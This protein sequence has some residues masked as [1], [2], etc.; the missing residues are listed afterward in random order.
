MLLMFSIDPAD[1][2]MDVILRTV[3]QHP[4]ISV[5]DLHA[6]LR[7]KKRSVTLQHLYRKVNQL[8]DEEILIKRK[9]T[10]TVNLMWLSYLE[11]FASEAKKSVAKNTALT[12]FPLREGQRVA[13]AADT[14][15]AVQT[16]WHHLLVQLHRTAPQPTLYKYYSHAWWVWNKR[17]LDVAFYKK[18]YDS[19]VRCLWLYGNNTDLDRSAV[20]M[21]PDILESRIS[22]DV[23]LPAEGYNLNV[24]G[25]YVFECIFPA[26]IARHLDLVFHATLSKKKEELAIIDDIFAMQAEYSV[27]VWRNATLAEKFRKQ[28]GQYFLFGAQLMPAEGDARK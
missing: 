13:F 4:G 21:Y 15:N 25:D 23:A 22:L 9:A 16:L 3:A 8:I 18:I 1:A 24:Y 11:F 5:A 10:L 28:I 27:T 7:K 26:H 2:L 6:A 19:G 20:T 17:T 14:M 12:V